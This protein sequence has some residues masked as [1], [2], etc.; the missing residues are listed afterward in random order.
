MWIQLLLTLRIILVEFSFSLLQC[1]NAKCYEGN[2]LIYEY[3]KCK[4]NLS[5]ITNVF[6]V[7]ITCLRNIYNVYTIYY[8]MAM[9]ITP[10]KAILFM[11]MSVALTCTWPPSPKITKSNIILFKACWY[12]CYFCNILL[13][14]PLLSS[15][16]E[17]RD[18]PVILAKSVCLSC[19]VLQVTIKMIV[20]RIQYTSFQVCII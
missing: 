16:Y 1:A 5:R 18:D 2:S 12:I 8:I 14:L 7:L 13:L 9:K 6:S 17:Y 11:K 4:E 15:V 19:A 3:R 10:V 20:C